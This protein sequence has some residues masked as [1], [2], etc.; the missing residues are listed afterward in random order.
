MVVSVGTD[1]P[2][3]TRRRIEKREPARTGSYTHTSPL[4]I[5]ATSRNLLHLLTRLLLALSLA[6]LKCIDSSR[7]NHYETDDGPRQR[8]SLQEGAPS[9]SPQTPCRQKT[10]PNQLASHRIAATKHPLRLPQN[11]SRFNPTCSMRAGGKSVQPTIQAFTPLTHLHLRQNKQPAS[12]AATDESAAIE[13]SSSRTGSKE[14][15]SGLD[16]P[17]P[18]GRPVRASPRGCHRLRSRLGDCTSDRP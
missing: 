4:C 2:L 9:L 1:V 11:L 18:S 5:S 6:Y 14:C 7:K 13:C 15:E 17:S 3:T 10:H 12:E 16:A 8:N